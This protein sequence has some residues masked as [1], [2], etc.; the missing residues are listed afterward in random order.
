MKVKELIEKLSIMPPDAELVSYQSVLEKS[1]IKPVNYAPTL[2][3]FKVETHYVY[4]MFNHTHI[5]FNILEED[6]DGEFIGV[7]M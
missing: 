7:E 2:K 6:E 1:G 4:D 3:N 5:T